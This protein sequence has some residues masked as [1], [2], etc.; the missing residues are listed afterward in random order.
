MRLACAVQ[1]ACAL[2]SRVA[3][4][5]VTTC[6]GQLGGRTLALSAAAILGAVSGPS[7]D[8]VVFDLEPGDASAPK[9]VRRIKATRPD[10]PVLIYYEPRMPIIERV[11]EVAPLPGVWTTAQVERLSQ[12]AELQTY[13]E[14]V[15]QSVPLVRLLHY[16]DPLLRALPSEVRGY[17]ESQ[18]GHRVANAP[19]ELGI[20]DTARG[21]AGRR[22]R[23]ERAC[24]A[25]GVATPK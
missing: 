11:T 4:H 8:V 25:A 20:D 15:I 19:G 1:V 10:W 3:L 9:F 6:V 24:Q 12:P 2:S 13:L 18:L 7:I 23:L 14:H 16:V 22:R 21:L 17:L 5:R